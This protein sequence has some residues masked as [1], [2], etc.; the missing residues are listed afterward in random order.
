MSDKGPR[1]AIEIAMERLREKDARE[2][3]EHRPLTDQQKAAIAEVRNFYDAKL[4]QE[5]V[6][7]KSAVSRVFDPEARATLQ[8]EYSR[9]R[10]RAIADR[11]AKIERIRR[12]EDTGER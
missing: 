12:G 8:A 5:E 7:H 11:D 6:M 2:G 4:A 1:S 3:I 9:D 10:Q